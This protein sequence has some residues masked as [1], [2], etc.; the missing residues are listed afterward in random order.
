MAVVEN[1]FA[2]NPE[3]FINTIDPDD[4]E[5]RRQLM[6]PA[7]IKEDL[8]LMSERRRVSVVLKSETFRKEL[9]E[10][11]E[12]Y[13]RS[14]E[15][16]GLNSS[17]LSLQHIADLF[18]TIPGKRPLTGGG[19]TK[20]HQNGIIPIN[21]LRGS[22][23]GL[24]SRR[25]RIYRCKLA[26]V[27]RLIELFGWNT[28][29]YNHATVRINRNDEHFLINPFGLLYHEV[30]ASSLIKVDSQGIVLDP[31]STV[32]EVDQA[33]WLFHSA[34]HSTRPDIRCVVH[35]GTPATIA[36]SCM[37]T[38]LL[39]LSQQAIIL[40]E[41]AYYT[42]QHS[43][44]G[45][46]NEAASGTAPTSLVAADLHAERAALS[47]VIGQDTHILFVRCRGLFALGETIEEAWHYA[48]NAVVACE[49]QLRLA[50]LG[51]DHLVL[52][53]EQ[54]QKRAYE[55]WRTTDLG[56]VSGPEAAMAIRLVHART[57]SL[58]RQNGSAAGDAGYLSDSSLAAHTS[59]PAR[60][61]RLGE[62]EFEALM[63]HL[64]NAGY[65][66]GH[67]YRQDAA[68]SPRPS[69]RTL[70]RSGAIAG[71]RRFEDVEI[72]PFT[73]SVATTM[74]QY[75]DDA[76]AFSCDESDAPRPGTLRRQWSDQKWLN[77]PN[78]YTKEVSTLPGRQQPVSHWVSSREATLQRE[79]SSGRLPPPTP[80]H[81]LTPAAIPLG[82]TG[83][84]SNTPS[85][86]L[87]FNR[88]APQ[89]DDPKELK[90]HQK[91]V[92]EKYYKD[93]NTAG[94][95]SRLLEGLTWDE[96]R[97][98]R[99]EALT[100]ALGPGA[101]STSL[102]DTNF[103]VAAAS[104]AILHRDVRDAAVVYDAVYTKQN[105]FG[106][107]TDEELDAYKREIELKNNPALYEEWLRQQETEQAATK[108]SVESKATG[109]AQSPSARAGASSNIFSDS[110]LHETTYVTGSYLSP[111]PAGTMT[112]ET[113]ELEESHATEKKQ[114]KKRRFKLPSF[115]RKTRT[116]QKGGHEA[117]HTEPGEG[118]NVGEQ[119]SSHNK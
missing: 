33:G 81:P 86:G 76:G 72:P 108:T 89:G 24:Y 88:F 75:Y 28:S 66:T 31:G 8:T 97:R 104:K 40:G 2:D 68:V 3:K 96:A 30:T 45:D 22:D 69:R 111:P 37:K 78:S 13:L 102:P 52:P 106:Q 32:L 115:A 73:S 99:D 26:C 118:P 95:Q 82:T 27:Y 43:L 93:T 64:D 21:D 29:I 34:L 7:E 80:F 107:V 16:T 58:S 54:V 92:R 94:P 12:N 98:I 112:S 23:T 110:E 74:A 84:Q 103:T 67:I 15:S 50:S 100:K 79:I 47:K 39:P 14:Q 101:V 116:K 1:G 35:L 57:L 114:K 60:P 85:S 5:Y 61:W 83:A 65:R 20:S 36:V 18:S 90:E 59:A 46:A 87:S 17:L 71:S 41:V 11:I 6:R 63:R 70:D 42:S 51:V 117:S 38:G 109:H 53:D 55:A 49:T 113:S 10:I 119:S 4:P 91:K 105:P 44:P 48:T 77:T 62:L 19:F 9:E 25:E 56:G